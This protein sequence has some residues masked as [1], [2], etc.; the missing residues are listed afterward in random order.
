MSW[1]AYLKANAIG[2]VEEVN[3]FAVGTTFYSKALLCTRRVPEA[4]GLSCAE[5]APLVSEDLVQ[6]DQKAKESRKATTV[7]DS[8][9]PI[10]VK[11]MLSVYFIEEYS[12]A[13]IR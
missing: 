10:P 1:H 13:L 3:T 4:T 2:N 6:V 11:F 12:S 5:T 8:G 7:L 9:M